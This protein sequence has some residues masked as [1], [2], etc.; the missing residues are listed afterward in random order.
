MPLYQT[1]QA[2]D[3]KIEIGNYAMYVGSVGATATAITTN[4]GAGAV[5]SF[6]YAPEMFTSQAGNSPDP[7]AGVARETCTLEIE[8]IEYDASAFSA[9]SNGMSSLPTAGTVTVGGQVSSISGVGM[10]LVNQR[11]LNTGSTQTTTYVIQ[12]AVL[13]SGWSTSPKSDND[14]DPINVYTFSITCKQYATAQ[15]IYTKTVA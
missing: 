8:L 1:A 3:S 11:K 12:K 9:L 7:I 6:A 13:N 15:T 5:K 2:T 10:K 14:A 4:L